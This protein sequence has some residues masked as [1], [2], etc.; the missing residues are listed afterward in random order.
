MKFKLK[1]NWKSG[2]VKPL[3]ENE[4][5]FRGVLRYNNSVEMDKLIN[6]FASVKVFG[7]LCTRLAYSYGEGI[8]KQYAFRDYLI[9]E[10]S[11]YLNCMWRRYHEYKCSKQY[12]S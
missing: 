7:K 3:K 4:V 1:E 10:M 5:D 11:V 6:L 2:D 8:Y 12:V 9:I